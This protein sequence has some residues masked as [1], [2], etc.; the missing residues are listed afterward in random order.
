MSEVKK[1]NFWLVNEVA[2]MLNLGEFGKL[3]N[4]VGKTVKFLEREMDVAER[5]IS[6]ANF[7][8]K[9]KKETLEEK[10]EDA[11]ISLRESYTNI[12]PAS[13]KT[14]DDQKAFRE[15]YLSKIDK[16]EAKVLGLQ[17]ELKAEKDKLRAEVDDLKEEIA[18][19]KRRISQLETGKSK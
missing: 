19:R 16:A 17:E 13:I 9:S 5:S 7:N 2:K 15:K 6:T 3:E 4:F 12:D 11:E 8:F 10:I 18:V 14:N 1:S